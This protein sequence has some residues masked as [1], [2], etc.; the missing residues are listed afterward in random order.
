MMHLYPRRRGRH[1]SFGANSTEKGDGHR[2][3]VYFD[4]G[5][6]H[7]ETGEEWDRG[8]M[9]GF[10]ELYVESHRSSLSL[11]D[12]WRVPVGIGQSETKEIKR[13]AEMI[14]G[15]VPRMLQML[16]EGKPE[17]VKRHLTAFIA[18]KMDAEA[19]AAVAAMSAQPENHRRERRAG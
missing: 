15:H 5:G 8:I 3:E 18:Y 12:R 14:D 7:P 1:V 6:T 9:V 11:K 19:Q 10:G 17:Q 4:A 13:V 2:I 16:E